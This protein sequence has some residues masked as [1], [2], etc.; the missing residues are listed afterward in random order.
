MSRAA[1]FGLATERREAGRLQGEYYADCARRS[2]ST[3]S[4]ERACLCTAD[5][6]RES[7]R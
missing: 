7:T 5:R 3:S 2:V 4:T 6:T 1:A